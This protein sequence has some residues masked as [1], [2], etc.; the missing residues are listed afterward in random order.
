MNA[1]HLLMMICPGATPSPGFT[2]GLGLL[3]HY[4]R[5]HLTSLYTTI[6]EAGVA[7]P[8]TIPIRASLGARSVTEI[9]E[10]MVRAE[11]E[12]A[13]PPVTLTIWSGVLDLVDIQGLEEL[14]LTVGKDRVY[15]DVPWDYQSPSHSKEDRPSA[16]NTGGVL[17]T[18]HSVISLL[19]A[20]F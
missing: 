10:F 2:T 3:G 9:Q 13:F 15:V 7:A 19:T 20:M 12:P 18:L 11:A 16:R 4:T 14:V 17:N 1:S 6:L 8:I 5:D